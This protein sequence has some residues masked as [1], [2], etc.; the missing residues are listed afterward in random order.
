MTALQYPYDY[1]S[2]THNEM[3]DFSMP[4]SQAFSIKNPQL[5]RIK[6]LDRLSEFDCKIIA[7]AYACPNVRC[8]SCEW[9]VEKLR[10]SRTSIARFIGFHSARHGR[11]AMPQGEYGLRL[12]R[13]FVTFR[14]LLT[15]GIYWFFWRCVP[16]GQCNSTLWKG[17][18]S[19]CLQTPLPVAEVAD[20]PTRTWTF[21][22]SLQFC[23]SRT[24]QGPR[25][26]SKL[27]KWWTRSIVA[28]VLPQYI[29]YSLATLCTSIDYDRG[30]VGEVASRRN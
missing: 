3:D 5:T 6:R 8:P 26:L 2:I 24:V 22:D 14:S 18:Q 27:V 17:L 12:L 19:E 29:W 4:G 10:S 16:A 11:P 28:L 23:W 9:P 21:V 7:S 20:V 30:D 15:T 1:C 25:W 13:T